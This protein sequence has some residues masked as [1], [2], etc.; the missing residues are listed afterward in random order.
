MSREKRF[1]VISLK[2]EFHKEMAGC[3][4]NAVTERINPKN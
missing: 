2:D 3:Y 1:F 4:E